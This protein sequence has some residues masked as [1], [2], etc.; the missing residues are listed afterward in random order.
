MDELLLFELSDERLVDEDVKLIAVLLELE[1]TLDRSL[2]PLEL[3]GI[4]ENDRPNS[5]LQ[6]GWY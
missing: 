2:N 5:P 1:L 6:M 3:L 4:V